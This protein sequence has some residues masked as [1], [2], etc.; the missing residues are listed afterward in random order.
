MNTVSSPLD[1]QSLKSIGDP[2][3]VRKLGKTI[4]KD[5]PYQLIGTKWWWW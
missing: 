1:T 3:M 2:A 5:Y 4:A